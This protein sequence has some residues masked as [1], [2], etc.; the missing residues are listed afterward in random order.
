MLLNSLRR[1]E[2][3]IRMF[4]FYGADATNEYEKMSGRIASRIY[5]ILIIGFLTVFVLYS[6]LDTVNQTVI[7]K[8][9]S[10][11]MYYSLVAKHPNIICSCTTLDLNQGGFVH[12]KPIYHQVNDVFVFQIGNSHIFLLALF[13]GFRRF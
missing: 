1:F 11:D 6:S 12:V 2:R 8:V 3:W 4:S 13:I 5:I 7:I 9:T 10:I